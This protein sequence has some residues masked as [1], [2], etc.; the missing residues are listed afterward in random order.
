MAWVVT[1]SHSAFADDKNA[2]SE[3]PADV[4]FCHEAILAHDDDEVIA[5]CG[6]LI[7]NEKTAKDDRIRALTARAGVF[8]GRGDIDRA[9]VDYNT[10]LQLDPSLAYIFN[11]RGELWWE[12][13][14]RP[15]ALA[16]FATA[17]KLDPDHAAARANYKKLA[18][19]LERLGAQMAV[20]GKP[21][22]N[23]STVRRQVEKAICA[24]R[25]LADLD[26]NIASANDLVIR[27]ARS[28]RE[29]RALRHEQDEFIAQR[30]ANFGKPGYDLR[31]AMQDRLQRLVGADG[32]ER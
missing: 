19:E 10:V 31:K 2:P 18:L 26:R 4:S 17:I 30:H 14:E 7:E 24:S 3:A 11:A 25:E 9:I 8:R 6:V 16:D 22:F 29:A 5:N 32:Y 27:E 12:K 21:S 13:G 20:A 1:T 23:C 28:P 15:K